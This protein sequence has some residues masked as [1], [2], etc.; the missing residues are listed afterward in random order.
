[1]NKNRF[2]KSMLGFTL[3]EV[4]ITLG[5]IGVIAAF[6]IPTL[7]AN[8][9]KTQYV[10]TLKKAYT[11]MSG[12]LQQLCLDTNCGGNLA[13]TD[14]FS[15]DKNSTTLG[16]SLVKYLKLAKNCKTN[17][18]DGCMPPK[19]SIYFTGG[20]SQ[21]IN[22]S[23]DYYSFVTADG[24]AYS[25]YNYSLFSSGNYANCKF[26]PATTKVCATVTIDVNAAKLPNRYGRDMFAF[27]IVNSD[28]SFLY[29]SGGAKDNPK[30][31]NTSSG[32]GVN[33]S[34]FGPYCAGRI[35]E[36]GWQMNY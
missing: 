26:N 24:I 29:P 14:A 12:A 31:D 11:Q 3:A 23:T 10:T 32:C 17:A 20:T 18:L 13:N 30:W 36:D 35:V 15:I 25:I 21:N 34:T 1:M 33:G 7:I 4:L 9:Q 5:I 27:Y 2:V 8:Y 28:G 19:Y 6:T 16:D 22:T